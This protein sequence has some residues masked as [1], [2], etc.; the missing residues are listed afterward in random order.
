L[1]DKSMGFLTGFV[2]IMVGSNFRLL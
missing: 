1:K 2:W